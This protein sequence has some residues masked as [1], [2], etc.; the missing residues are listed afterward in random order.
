MIFSELVHALIIQYWTSMELKDY[1]FKSYRKIYLLSAFIF[2][3]KFIELYMSNKE[4]TTSCPWII[5]RVAKEHVISITWCRSVTVP[6]L[7]Y[8]REE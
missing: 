8:P 4:S 6:I 3:K 2:D 1:F 5:S 7:G